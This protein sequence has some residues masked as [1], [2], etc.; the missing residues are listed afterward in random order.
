M[1]ADELPCDPRYILTAIAETPS[2]FSTML[3]YDEP[4]KSLTRIQLPF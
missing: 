3:D 4:A 2:L 1:A